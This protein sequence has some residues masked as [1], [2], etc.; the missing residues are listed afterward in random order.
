MK[1]KIKILFFAFLPLLL[2]LLLSSCRV[3]DVFSVDSLIRAPK[4]TGEN[5]AIQQ[6][7]EASTGSN[8]SLVNPLFGDFRSAFVLYDYNRDGVDEAVV[9]YSPRENPDE[10]RMNILE[11]DNGVWGSVCD[12]SGNGS[13]VYKIDF[14]NFD[15]DALPE[16]AVTWTL[17]DSK[18]SKTLSLYKLTDSNGE[19][20][21]NQIAA[22]QIT[23]YLVFDIDYD[24]QNEVFYT[25]SSFENNI[26]TYSAALFRIDADSLRLI[27]ISD[28][29]ISKSIDQILNF[30]TDIKDAVY[31]IYIDCMTEDGRYFTEILNF[32]YVNNVLVRPVD[33]G[34]TYLSACTFRYEQLMCD[35]Y[36]GDYMI[37]I[38]AQTEFP[39][40]YFEDVS[41]QS[42]GS[43]YI[44]SYLQLTD[45]EL[46]SG[47]E[48]YQ[49]VYSKFRIR[50]DDFRSL[51][52]VV[53]NAATGS[54]QFRLRD[55]GETDDLLF[56]VSVNE[57][58][59]PENRFFIGITPLG[60]RFSF[61]QNMLASLIEAI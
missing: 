30:K 56:T 40:S 51:V 23:D 60:E 54:T 43:M 27:P 35:D 5:A 42:Y 26:T 20:T 53:Y 50:I 17:S 2:A 52:Y 14:V 13:E 18:R 33:S 39:G 28:V 4:L 37:E 21:L 45:G 9:F 34:G 7:F 49:N 11:C 29:G 55:G 6:A 24:G 3:F 57:A 31:N 47:A 38:P 1:R 8:V 61:T 12:V 36:D 10:V 25:Y 22:V 19:K 58:N 59:D 46:V 32:D 48:Y 44:T 15:R 16:I 41:Q